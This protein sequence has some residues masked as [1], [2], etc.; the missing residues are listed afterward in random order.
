MRN[1]VK[2][3]L[4]TILVSLFVGCGDGGGGGSSSSGGE[5]ITIKGKVGAAEF[6]ASTDGAS[7]SSASTLSADAT[8]SEAVVQAASTSTLTGRI[9]TG[10]DTLALSGFYD[11][12]TKTFSIAATAEGIQIEISGSYSG[13]GTITSATAEGAISGSVSDAESVTVKIDAP[14]TKPPLTGDKAGIPIGMQGVWYQQDDV[15]WSIGAFSLDVKGSGVYRVE[16]FSGVTPSKV[17]RAIYKRVGVN[18]YA[19][20]SFELSGS[21]LI[22]KTIEEV[23]SIEAARG[24]TLGI[25]RNLTR[26]PKSSGGGDGG[27]ADF[28]QISS[29]PSEFQ[30]GWSNDSEFRQIDDGADFEW[31]GK[32]SKGVVR[33]IAMLSKGGDQYRP[34]NFTLNSAKTQ[35][36]IREMKKTTTLDAA[37]TQTAEDKNVLVLTKEW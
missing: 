17:T 19:P 37:K 13:S 9:N 10:T 7:A 18:K 25:T 31:I 22:L 15:K 33:A 1:I 27:S 35:L 3:V 30:G 23:D 26:T 2:T 8:T 36:T 21:S 34:Y 24:A 11:S 32:D 4:L 12:A 14:A 29:I 28:T 6:I 20:V 5:S 16:E